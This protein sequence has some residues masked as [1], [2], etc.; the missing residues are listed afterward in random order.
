LTR[1]WRTN[2]ENAIKHGVSEMLRPGTA[3]IRI[4]RADGGARIDVEDDAGAYDE[5]RARGR[6]DGLGLQIVDRRIRS[7]LGR[8]SG[9]TISCVPDRLTRVSIQI[10]LPE[11]AA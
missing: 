1:E 9:V 4:R 10:P 3:R 11:A 7:L 6:G 8:G 5:R 2:G